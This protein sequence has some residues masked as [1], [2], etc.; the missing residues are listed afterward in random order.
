MNDSE[1]AMPEMGWILVIED[2]DASAEMLIEL[3]AFAGYRADAAGTLR[4]AVAAMKTEKYAAALVD[5]TLAGSTTEELI[6]QLMA[7]PRRPPV[8]IFS[9]RVPDELAAAGQR[10]EAAAVLQKPASMEKLLGTL[11]RVIKHA[12]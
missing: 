10:L 8:V 7:I 5:L 3:L 6:K 9:A 11:A 4:Q 1:V 12:A 2:D